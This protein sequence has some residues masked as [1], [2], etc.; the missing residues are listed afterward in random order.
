M[1]PTIEQMIEIL[2]RSLNPI[3]KSYYESY[4]PAAIGFI[5]AIRAELLKRKWQ[6]I[7]TAP[8]DGTGFIA[9]QKI[10]QEYRVIC[11]AYFNGTTWVIVAFHEGNTEFE[12][13]PTHW[14]HLPESPKDEWA[15][16]NQMP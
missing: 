1:T 14:Q 7:D 3:S 5:E 2:D 16:F 8:R 9:F 11:P 4:R 12:I 10:S 13:H 15:G 6:P